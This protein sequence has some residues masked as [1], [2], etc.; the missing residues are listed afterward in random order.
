MQTY[1]AG[2]FRICLAAVIVPAE[3]LQQQAKSLQSMT[4]HYGTELYTVWFGICPDITSKFRNIAIFKSFITK[5]K[6]D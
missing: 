1:E 5:K 3:K 4:P 2:A 6:S